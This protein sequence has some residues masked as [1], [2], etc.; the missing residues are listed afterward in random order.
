[1]GIIVNPYAVVPSIVTDNVVL[2]AA[3]KGANIDL[4]GSDLVF[5]AHGV[6]GSEQVLVRATHSRTAGN[7]QYEVLFN[8]TTGTGK[9]ALGVG[10]SAVSLANDFFLGRDN[11]GWGYQATDGKVYHNLVNVATWSTG[12]TGNYFGCVTDFGADSMKI[13][14]DGAL[15][16]TIT[17]SS[18]GAALF[19]Y[20]GS[21]FENGDVVGTA[22]FGATAF[23][24]PIGGATAWNIP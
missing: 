3:H 2:D 18:G 21:D 1:M 22:N 6:V 23:A 14:I 4:S 15:L 24:Y 12:T 16:G 7:R 19:P 8:S 11:F 5:T 13:Y 9:I 20:M 17:L 10:T